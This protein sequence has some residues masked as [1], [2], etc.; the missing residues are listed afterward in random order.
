[1]V[2][3]DV[4][5]NSVAGMK[6]QAMNEIANDGY[7]YI[8]LLDHKGE[9]IECDNGV[10]KKIKF[11]IECNDNI[12]VYNTEDIAFALSNLEILQERYSHEI[13]IMSSTFK[14]I[15]MRTQCYVGL[16]ANT[17]YIFRKRALRISLQNI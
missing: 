4:I 3:N 16:D 10:L 12:S 9:L 14:S 5:L 1:M 2:L 17:T 13:V 8:G 7:G 6:F 15:R 11:N